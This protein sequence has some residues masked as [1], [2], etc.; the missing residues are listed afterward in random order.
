MIPSFLKENLILYSRV[1]V[2]MPVYLILVLANCPVR[3]LKAIYLLSCKV[4]MRFDDFCK[5]ISLLVMRM[6][7]SSLSISSVL[8]RRKVKNLGGKNSYFKKDVFEV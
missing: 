4:T 6:R 3:I 8:V 2:E 5:T 7:I 1:L